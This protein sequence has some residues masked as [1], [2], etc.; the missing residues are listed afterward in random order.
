MFKRF[1]FLPNITYAY[2]FK[3][4]LLVDLELWIMNQMDNIVNRATFDQRSEPTNKRQCVSAGNEHIFSDLRDGATSGISVTEN[5]P[6]PQQEQC[7][8]EFEDYKTMSP[9]L[10]NITEDNNPLIFW[11]ENQRKFRIL[12]RLAKMLFA[13]QCSS[14]QSE[15]DFSSCGK[16]SLSGEVYFRQKQCRRW[17]FNIQPKNIKRKLV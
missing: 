2:L 6:Y 7:R 17:R 14:A 1:D 9:A 11:R 4:Q 8:Q 16:H 3:A 10:S 12:S 5:S 13:E 15:R